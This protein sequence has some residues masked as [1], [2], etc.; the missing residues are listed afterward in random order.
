MFGSYAEIGVRWRGILRTEF[1]DV[2]YFTRGIKYFMQATWILTLHYMRE[3]RI[4]NI[5]NYVLQIND[6]IFR[7]L[8]TP[9]FSPGPTSARTAKRLSTMII[10][11]SKDG[12]QI[13]RS[14]ELRYMQIALLLYATRNDGTLLARRDIKAARIVLM[15]IGRRLIKRSLEYFFSI[16][17]SELHVLI[18]I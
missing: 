16:A 11:C 18:E 1:A 5:A 15:F 7:P 9:L 2:I 12:N 4:K 6:V 17:R 13:A 10:Y 14:F 8:L 3:R